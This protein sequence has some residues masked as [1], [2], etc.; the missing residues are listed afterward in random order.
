MF[1]AYYIS[2]LWCL[3]TMVDLGHTLLQQHHLHQT[4][5]NQMTHLNQF[6]FWLRATY[7]NLALYESSDWRSNLTNVLI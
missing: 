4:Q 6:H 3:A 7:F 1:T 2:Y 5:M